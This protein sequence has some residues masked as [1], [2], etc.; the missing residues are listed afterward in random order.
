[1]RRT[2]TALLAGIAVLIATALASGAAAAGTGPVQVGHLQVEDSTAPIGIDTPNP[3]LSW[4]LLS[5]VRNEAQTGYQIVV[6]S[7]G[8]G[9]RTVWESGKV[10]SNTSVEVPYR[11]AALTSATAYRWRVRVW[12]SQG[13]PT[14]W[15]R[16]G[17][18]E[19][20][21]M[22]AAAWKAHWI[23]ATATTMSPQGASWIWYP[24][25]AAG[26]AT[27]PVET[28]YFRSSVR[29]P[30]GA[31]V[32]RAQYLLTADDAFDLSV[33]GKPLASSPRVTDSW[34]QAMVID[35][36]SLLHAGANSIAVAA[37]NTTSSPAGLLGRLH[38][39]LA[40][41]SVAD[42]VTDGSWKSHDTEVTGW[43]QPGFD[44]SSWPAALAEVGYGNGPW[45]AN[46]NV[47]AQSPYLR[48]GFSVGK[49]VAGARL[50]VTSL[51][52][53]EAYI[54]GAKVGNDLL[55][56]G[57][58][59]YS[60]RLQYQTYDVTGII[61]QG[62]NAIGALLGDGWYAGHV[63]ALGNHIY[64]TQ[65]WLLAD[66]RI[67]YTD[68]TSDDVGSDGSWR[69]AP[70]PVVSSDIY[71]GEDY[72]ALQQ[73]T[74]WDRAGYDDSAWAPA[75]VN[76]SV[77]GNAQIVAQTGPGIQ[78]DQE[79]RPAKMTQPQ[80]GHYVFDFGQNFAGWVRLRVSGPAGTRVEMGHAEVLNPDGTLYLANLRTAAATDS[81]TLDGQG[82]ETFEPHFTYHGFRYVELTGFP[83]TP[84]LD[85]VTGIVAHAAAPAA[86]R[87]S[88]SN[89][90]IN[91]IQHNIVW[92]QKSNFYSVPTDCPQRDERLGWMG[93][94]EIF[95]P[96]ATFN[97][98]LSG[99]YDKWIQDVGD[100]Q[101][102]DGGFTDV[103][104]GV[105]GGEGTPGW[106]D[107][108]VVVPYVVW[109]RYGDTQI[110]RS[111]WPAMQHW[112]SY[113]QANST[114]LLRPPIGYGDWLNVND[115]TPLDVI[116]TAYFGY[117]TELMAAMATAIGQTAQAA[118]YQQLF[119]QIRDAFDKAYVSAD[120][121]IKGDT[122]TDYVMALSMNLL[123]AALQS[124]AG[125]H[126]VASIKARG[127]H[128]STGFL[129]T[130]DLLPVLTQTGHTDVAYALLE[131]TTFPSWGYEI[132]KGATTI[133][134]R[135][136]GIKPDG[137][138]NDPGM[139]SFNHYGFGSVGDWMYQTIGG[140]VDDPAHPG[141]RQF[142]LHPQPG[143]GLTHGSARYASPYGLIVSDWTTQH[144]QF[145]LHAQVPPNSTAT[146][147]VPAIAASAV[148]NAAGAHFTGMRDGAAVYTVGSG[149]YTFTAHTAS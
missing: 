56:P 8:K 142:S 39:D 50:Y 141:Y 149:T 105:T 48:H 88:T 71:M 1:M 132:G 17:T 95:A 26:G 41:G 32:R 45:G 135:W 136:D 25:G 37:T 130:G 146:V 3:R 28:R 51:G 147:Y 101:R 91:E 124:A 11:G 122:Q 75:V 24:E 100:A 93:D 99:F 77:L 102:P 96:T 2:L 5:G 74:G 80:P 66:L 12:D 138:F 120:G 76:D 62:S 107:A 140:I 69:T 128:L 89:P 47:A 29:I 148:T 30:A 131:Q 13:R 27:F 70:S 143:G 104:P 64:G 97:M 127:M 21:L 9:H 116:G 114:N 83:G 81:Y 108:G 137:T 10:T 4:Q 53:Y 19:T 18:F 94:A 42:L 86:G 34:K 98:D 49:Q 65:P 123:P 112:I 139:N 46:V 61:K 33:N 23:G 7:A 36:T 84:T 129:G 121:T 38:V 20:G 44:D 31:T 57:W 118:Q 110:I 35:V 134:E 63:A 145:T 144:G 59:D 43:Q 15:S 103:S 40:G 109:Q 16:T 85:A 55:T 92:G 79:L 68:G 106:G 22:S 78:Q 117:S 111:S 60:K 82:V 126:L 14:N 133:W 87:F 115:N 113:L 52:L 125:D 90:L 58:T 119:T 54:N 6:A 67:D 72:D 73:Q